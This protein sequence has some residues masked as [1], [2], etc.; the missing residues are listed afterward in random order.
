MKH[1]KLKN[2]I[3]AAATIIIPLQA[4]ADDGVSIK[5][6]MLD[7]S[8]PNEYAL[9]DVSRIVFGEDGFTMNFLNNEHAAYYAYD[10]VGKI[11]FDLLPTGIDNAAVN[12]KDVIAVRYDGNMLKI[13]GCKES[14]NVT[15]YEITGRPVISRNISGDTTV[16]TDNLLAGVYILKVNNITFKFSKL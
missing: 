6:V 8:S 2:L 15:V 7:G 14:A 16:S 3:M 13:T 1:L 10:D 11:M 12:N 5:V 4:S 9:D